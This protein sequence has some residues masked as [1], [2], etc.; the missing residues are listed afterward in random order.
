[1]AKSKR[2]KWTDSERVIALA[3]YVFLYKPK[4]KLMQVEKIE[5]NW[6]LFFKNKRTK[7]SIKLRM[8]NYIS[9]DPTGKRKGLD[10]GDHDCKRIWNMYMNKDNTPSQA[11]IDY[12]IDYIYSFSGDKT[13][14][15]DF[16][17]KYCD[18]YSSMIN[19]SKDYQKEVIENSEFQMKVMSLKPKPE[20]NELILAPSITNENKYLQYR[21]NPQI[22]ANA[23]ANA[24]DMCEIDNSHITFKRKSN[25]RP[26]LE[27]HHL[28]PLSF[29]KY[30]KY[31]L[32][33]TCNVVVLCSNCHNKLHFGLN[34]END[35][36]KLYNLRI[37]GM[38]KNHIDIPFESLLKCYQDPNN[39]I[40]PYKK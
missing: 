37:A 5:K 29:Q 4:G 3:Y 23:L 35:L 14:Y 18:N 32:D 33:V 30:F 1:M 2:I 9:V 22:A 20:S 6:D 17:S 36:R 13:L 27:V 24:K 38:K 21:R 25:S 40:L 8:E 12:F 16:F 28:I 11:L 34:I 31:S 19:L 26:Y 7:G 15:Y 10:G 39:C